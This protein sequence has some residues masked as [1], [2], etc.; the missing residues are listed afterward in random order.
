MKDRKY[1]VFVGIG[2]E[3]VA[4]I[5]GC[6]YLGMKLDEKYE[7]NGMFLVGMSLLGLAGWLIHIVRLLKYLE[8][9]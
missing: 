1:L 9:E 6:I 5:L 3:L 7:G 2:F 4:I 8:K